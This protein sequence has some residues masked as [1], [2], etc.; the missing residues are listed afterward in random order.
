[1][2]GRGQVGSEAGVIRPP[3]C[4]DSSFILHPSSFRTGGRPLNP[5][6]PPG[7]GTARPPR[8]LAFQLAA[9]A[10]VAVSALAATGLAWW[11]RPRHAQHAAPPPKFP[12]RVFEGWDRPDLVIVLT[13]Q[14]HGY[15][16]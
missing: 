3:C 4:P 13:G 12:G 2:K 14:Q 11:L 7:R 8:G 10:L 15:L 9:V 5:T 16:L 6:T 1:M